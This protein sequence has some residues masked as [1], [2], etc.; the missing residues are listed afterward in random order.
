MNDCYRISQALCLRFSKY[1][2]MEVYVRSVIGGEGGK[3]I[4]ER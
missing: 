3:G 1:Q 4:E 2:M